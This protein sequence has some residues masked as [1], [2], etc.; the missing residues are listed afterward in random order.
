MACYFPLQAFRSSELTSTGK[1]SITFDYREAFTSDI[2]SLPCGRCIGC[3]LDRSRQWACRCM[4]ESSLHDSNSFV[5]LTFS[6][7]N[8]PYANSLSVRTFQLFMKRLRFKFGNGIRFYGCGEYGDKLG[9][10][11]YHAILF[12]LDFPDKFFWKMSGDYPIYRSPSLESVWS[13]GHSYI[14]AVTFESA[15]YVARYV[16]KKITGDLAADH[17]VDVNTGV[18]R[19][20]EFNIMSRNPGVAKPW[21]DRYVSDVY[22]HDFVVIR[23]KKVKPPRYFDK[24]FEKAFP[25]QFDELKIDRF[26][27]S[28]KRS[29]EDAESF[30]SMYLRSLHLDVKRRH[31]ELSVSRLVRSFD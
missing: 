14:G 6:D 19:D 3:R 30:P 26:N 7:E 13:Y 8:L 29:I 24:L 18:V 1:R 5:T 20:P 10:P 12:G 17:Y 15:A 2:L 28:L 22:P 11:H 4:L 27:D 21:L 31:K 23:G 9:R 25:D 16:M